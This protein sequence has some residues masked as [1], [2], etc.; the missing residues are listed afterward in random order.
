MG[1]FDRANV[2]LGLLACA[3]ALMV[4]LIWVPLD[5]S[6]GLIEKVRRQVTIGDGLAPTLAAGFILLG[7]LLVLLFEPTENARRVTPRNL[8][9][10]CTFLLIV[11]VA[12]M[13]MRW[14]G[15]A[16]GALILEDGYR[17]LR[18]TAPWKY[19]GF[20]LGG[21]ILIAGLIGLVEGRVSLRGVVLGLLA[22]LALIAVYDLPFDDLLLPP[23]GDV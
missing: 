12:F 14:A 9:F 3:M 18:D 2:L 22:A 4:A 13:I 8:L 1:R 6:T 10:L 11:C 20:I 17:P 21:T 5:T 16:I 23:N 15:P 7:G 19:I